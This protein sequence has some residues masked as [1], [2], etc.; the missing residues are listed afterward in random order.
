MK[1]SWNP[2]QSCANLLQY[3]IA[4]RPAFPAISRH[5]LNAP[6]GDCGGFHCRFTYSVSYLDPNYLH[7][8]P[9]VVA[10]DMASDP[11]VAV[12]MASDPVVAVDMASDPVVVDL[13]MDCH[14]E[15]DIVDLD[16][17]L[18]SHLDFL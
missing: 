4:L 1:L 11:V 6:C 15:L 8:Q 12:D 2:I 13:H 3:C 7:S 5:L 16:P 14:L 18:V 9:V 17:G 10:V